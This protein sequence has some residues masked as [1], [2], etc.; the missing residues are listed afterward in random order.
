MRYVMMRIAG[1]SAAVLLLAGCGG[2]G[3]GGNGGPDQS[4]GAVEDELAYDMGRQQCQD[5][6]VNDL[7]ATYGTEATPE[8]VAAAVART[9][10]TQPGSREDVK[11]G[12]LDGLKGKGG[13]GGS[14]TLPPPE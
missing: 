9:T 6:S 11:Q 12:C 1:I 14:D 13:S 7:A 5:Y 8:A 2:G 4:G 10:P 3:N